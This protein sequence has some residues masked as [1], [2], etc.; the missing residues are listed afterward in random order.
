M[1]PEPIEMP[2]AKDDVALLQSFYGKKHFQD[3]PDV[4]D[5]DMPDIPDPDESDE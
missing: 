4:A 3:E 2:T 5:M 1:V